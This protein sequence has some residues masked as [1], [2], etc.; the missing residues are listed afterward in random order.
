MSGS[1]IVLLL[2]T[3]QKLLEGHS[4]QSSPLTELA[5]SEGWVKGPAS[6]CSQHWT[7]ALAKAVLGASSQCEASDEWL[8]LMG[9]LNCLVSS[10][11]A[12]FLRGR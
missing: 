6:H 4:E 8:T 5:E 3:F 9:C 11:A 10:Q 2:H 7:L 12:I 1:F